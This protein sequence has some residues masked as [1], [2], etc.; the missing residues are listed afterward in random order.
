M[1]HLTLSLNF[2]HLENGANGSA[3]PWGCGENEGRKTRKYWINV[4]YIEKQ[5]TKTNNSNKAAEPQRLAG[6][7]E[8][9]VSLRKQEFLDTV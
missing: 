4:I 8:H 2:P 9:Y 5:K 1:S 6:T 7:G 3:C